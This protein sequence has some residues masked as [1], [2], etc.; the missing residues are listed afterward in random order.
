MG[1]NRAQARNLGIK[2]CTSQIIAFIDADCVAP[3]NWLAVIVENLRN[4]VST[5]GVGGTNVSPPDSSHLG[6]AIDQVF[7]SPLGSLGSASLADT[8]KPKKVN[9]LACI[10]SAFRCE[11][12][13]AIGGFDEE[14]EL[15]EDT[16]LSY[17]A[18]DRG[19][20]LLFLREYF[21]LALSKRYC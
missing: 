13:R 18:N 21:S 16:N 8:S 12:L 3:K 9:A 1:G 5:V 11:I 2:F 19:G 7:L 15:C 10:N 14:F 20:D 6:H 4:N 17:K